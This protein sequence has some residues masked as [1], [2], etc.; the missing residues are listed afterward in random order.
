MNC[1]YI[2]TFK[3][4]K[5]ASKDL[6]TLQYIRHIHDDDKKPVTT[7]LS[8]ETVMQQKQTTH[9]IN[10]YVRGTG[11]SFRRWL[12]FILTDCSY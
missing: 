1:H 11:S 8:A 9:K 3:H 2:V 10:N 12:L 7:N 6:K 4:D 5:R